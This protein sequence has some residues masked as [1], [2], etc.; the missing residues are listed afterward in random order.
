MCVYVPMCVFVCV[1]MFPS[2]L[3][4]F[5]QFQNVMCLLC[6]PVKTVDEEGLQ[7]HLVTFEGLLLNQCSWKR[8]MW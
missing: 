6:P 8:L 1:P 5:E 7:G 3:F 2:V 4:Y